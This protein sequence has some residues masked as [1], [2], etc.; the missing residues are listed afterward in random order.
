MENFSEFMKGY[1]EEN[2]PFDINALLRER[3]KSK[4]LQKS[5]SKPKGDIDMKNVTYRPREKRYIGRK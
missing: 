1:N 5:I 3:Q 4:E 2:Q